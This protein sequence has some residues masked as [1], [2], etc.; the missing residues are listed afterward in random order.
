MFACLY[1]CAS[2]GFL[3]FM[4]VQS[5]LYLSAHSVAKP[6]HS[7]Y[8]RNTKQRDEMLLG[9]LQP[10]IAPFGAASCRWYRSIRG[11]R[12]CFIASVDGRGARTTPQGTSG[13]WYQLAESRRTDTRQNESSVQKLLFCL[14]K[15]IEPRSSSCRILRL[16]GRG[17][18]TVS[19]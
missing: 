1:E 12:R 11:W 8:F 9:L 18:K 17:T 3:N 4:K 19:D 7:T 16:T 2:F 13:T 15:E 5:E 6:L 10:H 14:P